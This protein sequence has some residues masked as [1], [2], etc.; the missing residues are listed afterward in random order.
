MSLTWKLLMIVYL[1]AV[2]ILAVLYLHDTFHKHS[3]QATTANDTLKATNSLAVDTAIN[4]PPKLDSSTQYVNITADA[5]KLIIPVVG[6]KRSELQD[7]YDDARSGGRVH[8]AIDIIAPGGTPVV[9]ATDG[10]IAKFFD[11][12][13]GGIT[14]YQWSKDST[15]IY[16]YAHLQRRAPGLAEGTFVKRGTLIGFVGDTGDAGAGNFHLH[17]GISIPTTPGHYWGGTDINPYPILKEG[18]EV[19]KT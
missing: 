9:A 16:Y 4:G 8:D 15:R 14:I 18:I 5:D 13:R 12:Q 17:F 7:T 2:H 3:P 1:L 11:S 10:I 19:P 6:V